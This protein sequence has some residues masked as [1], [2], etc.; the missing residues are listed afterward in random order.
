MGLTK[1][2]KNK[3]SMADGF[4]HEAHNL[5]RKGGK[6]N[7]KMAPNSKEAHKTEPAIGKY[8]GHSVAFGVSC[9]SPAPLQRWSWQ[10][11]Y[12]AE[13]VRFE[14]WRLRDGLFSFSLSPP[15]SWKAGT[16]RE[17]CS[18][19]TP[20]TCSGNWHSLNRF[21]IREKMDKLKDCWWVN[22]LKGEEMRLRD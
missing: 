10:L 13:D 2:K 11:S 8:S 5:Q 1:E 17:G 22:E 19:V 4:Y 14:H 6:C 21:L 3:W 20:H 9:P 16:R 12:V 18:W 7:T 15:W